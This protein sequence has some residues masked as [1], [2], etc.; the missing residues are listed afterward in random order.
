MQIINNTFITNFKIGDNIH[1]NLEVLRSLYAA[2]ELLPENRKKYL[3]KPI[4]V[5]LVSICEAIIFD[6]IERSKILT[7]EGI[8]GLSDASL[9]ELRE[10]NTWS[11]EKKINLFKRLDILQTNDQYVYEYLEKLSWLRNRV[12]IQNEKNRFEAHEIKAFKKSRR[13]EAEKMLELLMKK[14][15]E[16]YPRPVQMHGYVNNF[17]LPWNEYFS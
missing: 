12:H 8:T 3:E 4:T 9:I 6:F 14:I 11:F 10:S 16:L 13:I 2:E 5:T 7:R 17:E 15:A 1:Y